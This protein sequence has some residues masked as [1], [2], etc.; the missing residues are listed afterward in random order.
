MLP[1]ANGHSTPDLPLLAQPGCA[2][3][4][5]QIFFGVIDGGSVEADNSFLSSSYLKA[6]SAL[7]P[8]PARRSAR[9][10]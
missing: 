3:E 8:K 2:G 4:R 5:R 10:G 1:P 6:Q 9:S 7:A